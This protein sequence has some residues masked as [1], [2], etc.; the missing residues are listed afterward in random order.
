MKLKL[1][2]GCGPLSI[3][4]STRIFFFF[5]VCVINEIM[6]GSEELSHG[7]FGIVVEQSNMCKQLGPKRKGPRRSKIMMSVHNLGLC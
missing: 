3:G 1:I 6:K 4:Q 7:L 5:K 2:L